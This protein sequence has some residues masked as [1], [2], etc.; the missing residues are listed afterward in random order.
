[1]ALSYSG[2]EKMPIV[3]A[4]KTVFGASSG[5]T[6]SFFNPIQVPGMVIAAVRNSAALP[7]PPA[8][9][10]PHALAGSRPPN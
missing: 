4:P 7:G 8:R 5:T 6:D 9:H 3:L 10:R 1:M 2:N